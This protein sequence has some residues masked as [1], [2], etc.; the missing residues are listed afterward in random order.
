MDA[1]RGL[2]AGSVSIDEG[3]ARILASK[4]GGTPEFWLRRQL[5]YERALDRAVRSLID[6]EGGDLLER[7]PIPG[8]RLLGR[9]GD[10]RK[11]EELRRRLAFFNVNSLRTWLARYACWRSETQFRTSQTLLSDEGAVSIWLR[12]GEIEAAMTPTKPWNSILL[13]EKLDDIR[14]LSKISH[15]ARFLPKLKNLCAAA[16]VALVIVRT[17][18]GCRASGATRFLSPDKAM[19]LLS[20]RFRADDQFW[21]TVFH[22]LGHLLLHGGRTFVDDEETFQDDREQEANEFASDC[23]I[24][25]SR[26][27]ELE[28][29]NPNRDAILRFSVSLGV[30][31][32]VTVGQ[33]QHRKMIGHNRFNTLKRHWTWEEIEPA[34]N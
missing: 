14:K 24:P 20:F 26:K 28:R 21:F 8:G 19:I 22:E 10:T 17:P 15:P 7:V 16:G 34:L 18:K 33:M 12:Q 3:R 23:I 6:T 11:E 29:L 1:L 25:K 2:V 31:P 9:I 4:L 13:R 32:G 30:A 5:N 27:A